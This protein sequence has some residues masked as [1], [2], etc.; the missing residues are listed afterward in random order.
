MSY[1]TVAKS[2]Y[3]NGSPTVGNQRI[4]EY[5]K[6]TYERRKVIHAKNEVKRKEKAEE[7]LKDV[8]ERKHRLIFRWAPVDCIWREN[9][10]AV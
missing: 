3:E 9:F 1:L 7:F 10:Q 8:R 6:Q 2:N 4:K 5:H